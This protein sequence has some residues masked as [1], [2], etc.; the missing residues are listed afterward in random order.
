MR[1]AIHDF[2][3]QAAVA[4]EDTVTEKGKEKHIAI[5]AT[6]L[7]IL[8]WF[9]KFYPFMKK[10]IIDGKEY[11]WIK[12]SKVIEDL[13]ILRIT[14]ESVSARLKKLVHFKLLDYRL[15][16]E[17]GT[18][19]YYTLG[20]SY[21]HLVYN[22]VDNSKGYGVNPAGGTGSTPHPVPGQPGNKDSK[23]NSINKYKGRNEGFGQL[24]PPPPIPCEC[25]GNMFFNIQTSRYQ[26]GS[27]LR[28]VCPKCGA[29]VV[30]DRETDRYSCNC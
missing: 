11:G 14:E 29:E 30:F 7:L 6:D 19:C 21:P 28:E 23:L 17:D 5:D 22:S 16:K 26:C 10:K 12:R 27:C 25:G 24:T 13:P 2:N 15:V 18:F 9:A 4:M 20:E 1:L 8:D 3:Q